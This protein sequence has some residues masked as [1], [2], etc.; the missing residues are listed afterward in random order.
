MARVFH[1]SIGF[2]QPG[3]RLVEPVRS[4]AEGRTLTLLD[5]IAS[6]DGTDLAY[7]VTY[8]DEGGDARAR[9]W[10]VI[11]HG[12]REYELGGGPVAIW[13][14]D[15]VWRREIRSTRQVPA[16][17]GRVEVE[18]AV[19]GLGEWRVVGQLA[20]YGQDT[21][22]RD[23][24][25]ADT[26]DG[27]TVRLHGLSLSKEV[28]AIEMSASTSAEGVFVEGIGAYSTTRM[29][30]TA[31]TLR[32]QALRVYREQPHDPRLDDA[33][34]QGRQ[35]ALFEAIPEDA[36]EF[37]LEIPYVYVQECNEQITFDVP[38]TAPATIAY[39]RHR[40]RVL[41]T[42]IAPGTTD[43]ASLPY[44]EPGLGVDIDLG[45]WQDG[46]RILAP[47]LVYVDG[48]NRGRRYTNRFD[49]RAPEPVQ[50][51]EIPMEG[52]HNAA[53]VKLVGAL[54]QVHGPWEIRFRR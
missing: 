18:V 41:R 14:K 12:A 48:A 22:S 26:H 17:A 50:Q 35:F 3:V 10:I 6:P 30:P 5:L 7:E 52:A 33:L 40:A 2:R 45:G 51:F 25:E 11:R 27:I 39:G 53:R 38:V 44:R 8:A 28:A 32:D 19:S 54:V 43:A 4:D 46:R 37:A 16:T 36:R 49:A 13:S 24:D 23:L 29:G 31:L 20:A 15:G 9:E 34:P 21:E 1:A 47:R 42:Y